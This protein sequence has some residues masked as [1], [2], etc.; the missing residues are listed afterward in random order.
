M[1]RP[2]LETVYTKLPYW[3]K[4]KHEIN[5]Y[6]CERWTNDR[7]EALSH[8]CQKRKDT[9]KETNRAL[10]K[11]GLKMFHKVTKQTCVGEMRNYWQWVRC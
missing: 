8:V 2:E 3:G 10:D 6:S 1:E 9:Q 5:K 7:K 11:T 4:A